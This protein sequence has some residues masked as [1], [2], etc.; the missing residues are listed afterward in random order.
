MNCASI[1][2]NRNGEPVTKESSYTKFCIGLRNS[3]LSKQNKTKK[4]GEDYRLCSI[5]FKR[6]TKMC[7]IP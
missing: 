3:G 4:T 6:K 5:Q 7:A 1:T 2:V